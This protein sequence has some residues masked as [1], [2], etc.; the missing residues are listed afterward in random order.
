MAI[1]TLQAQSVPSASQVPCL[2]LLPAGWTFD[3]ANVRN[4]WSTFTLDHDRVGRAALV[5]QLTAT[6]DTS[7]TISCGTPSC[8]NQVCRENALLMFS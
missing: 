3:S 6:C 5:V 8:A 2:N 1:E 4:G 7:G